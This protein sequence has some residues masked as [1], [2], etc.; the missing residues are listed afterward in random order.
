MKSVKWGAMMALVMLFAIAPSQ[1][2]AKKK[3]SLRYNLSKGDAYTSSTKVDQNIETKANGQTF[4]IHQVMTIDTK[5]DVDAV[6]SNSI[7]TKNAV[8]R[9]SMDQSVMGQELKFDT[10]D[11]SSYASGRAKALGEA[12]NK[13]INKI[14]NVTIDDLG[15]IVD[16]NMNKLGKGNSVVGGN[17]SSNSYHI[18]FPKN[19]VSVGDTWEADIKPMKATGSKVHMKY[20]LKKISGR[21][22]E[23]AMEGTISPGGDNQQVEMKGIESGTATVDIKTGWTKSMTM[24]QEI[25]MTVHRNG[26]AMPMNVNSTITYTSKKK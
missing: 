1:S 12:M 5:I 18:V 15:N 14:F 9:V 10:S 2:W 17:N 13:V 22:V 25:K 6:S 8:T 4:N 24:D 23:I 16:V 7:E 21:T 11:P 20:T 26:M 3:V 19:K